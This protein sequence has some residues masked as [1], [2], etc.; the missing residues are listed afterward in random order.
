[1]FLACIL[2]TIYYKLYCFQDFQD[3]YFKTESEVK[4]GE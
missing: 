2:K 1:M 3:I 4:S